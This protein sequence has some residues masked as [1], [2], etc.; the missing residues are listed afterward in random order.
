MTP[1]S[2]ASG[3]TEL[4]MSMR[5]PRAGIGVLASVFA[6]CCSS[7][8]DIPE[9]V[10]LRVVDQTPSAMD[11]L[12]STNVTFEVTNRSTRAVFLPRCGEEVA[13]EV[14]RSE[15]D[16]WVNA[17]AAF[18]LA[19]LRQNAIRLEPGSHITSARGVS[20]TGRFR[21]RSGVA[22]HSSDAMPWELFS[23]PFDIR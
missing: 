11:I 17:S 16:A 20:G 14:E 9:G 13:T 1:H 12:H 15:A 10:Y 4:G 6:A 3:E 19:N 18:C 5:R 23:P 8:T 7:P 2:L 22:R 21:L